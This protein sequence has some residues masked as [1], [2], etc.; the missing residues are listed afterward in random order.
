MCYNKDNER[1]VSTMTRFTYNHKL[2]Y[3]EFKELAMANY[4]NGGDAVVEC[5]DETAF[6]YYCE[7]FGQ[8]TEAD[9][10]ALFATYKNTEK[11]CY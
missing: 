3:K 8:M 1:E 7:E 9:A 4:N 10:L 6:R 5:W 2:S 11:E